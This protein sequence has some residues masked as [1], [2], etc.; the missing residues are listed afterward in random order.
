MPPTKIIGHIEEPLW[1]EIHRSVPIVCVDIAAVFQE[2]VLLLKRCV[3]PEAGK[4]WFPGGRLYR[5]EQMEEAVRRILWDETGLHVFEPAE[6]FAWE[7]AL[8]PASP[9]GYECGTH[10]VN[11]VYKLMLS[12]KNTEGGLRINGLHEGAIWWDGEPGSLSGIGDSP[13]R[14]GRAVLGKPPVANVQDDIE[15]IVMRKAGD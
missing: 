3:E 7:N 9:W 11:F 15:K 12:E 5:G 8:Y 2:K 6:F 14:L 13:R 1:K 10:T 4:W